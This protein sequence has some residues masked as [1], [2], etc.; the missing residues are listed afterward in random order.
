MFQLSLGNAP[1]RNLT[2]FPVQLSSGE[3]R[4]NAAIP[5]SWLPKACAWITQLLDF[6]PEGDIERGPLQTGGSRHRRFRS[7]CVRCAACIC[8]GPGSL[9]Q[10]TGFLLLPAQLLVVLSPLHHDAAELSALHALFPLSRA[11]RHSARQPRPRSQ[12]QIDSDRPLLPPSAFVLRLAQ[13]SATAAAFDTLRIASA[14]SVEMRQ[15]RSQC[16]RVSW[17]S[18][19]PSAPSTSASGRVN[20]T[21][22]S[23]SLA[24]SA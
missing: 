8:L 3:A 18:P 24:S 10:G 20:G 7:R 19:L 2:G 22:S 12:I 11:R 1:R 6:G 16:S 21:L 13:C 15:R 17:R 23:A 14:L 9:P 4:S 5:A